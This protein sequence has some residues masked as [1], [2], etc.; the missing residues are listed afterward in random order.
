MCGRKNWLG[1]HETFLGIRANNWMS[2]WLTARK[3]IWRVRKSAG[4]LEKVARRLLN[5]LGG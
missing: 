2:S 4:Y 5:L 3:I 1:G